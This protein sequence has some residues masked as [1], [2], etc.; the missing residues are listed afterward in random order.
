ML[1][2]EGRRGQILGLRG[3]RRG[4]GN[5]DDADGFLLR[6]M[7]FYMHNT[8]GEKAGF[9]DEG[10]VGSFV[11]IDGAMRSEAVKKPERAVTDWI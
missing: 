10:L 3:W 8:G 5:N 6:K 9:G 1:R 2:G 7:A 4:R 11:Y